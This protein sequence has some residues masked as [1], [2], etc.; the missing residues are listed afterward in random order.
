MVK[1]NSISPPRGH[2]DGAGDVHAC[3]GFLCIDL[4]EKSVPTPYALVTVVVVVSFAVR[5]TV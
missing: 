5:G 2:T 3:V 1:V 4:G